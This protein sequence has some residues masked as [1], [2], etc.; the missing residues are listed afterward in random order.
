MFYQWK[1]D[2]RIIPGACSNELS[3]SDVISSD[4]G[5][6]TV[7][8][9]NRYGSTESNA[10]TLNVNRSPQIAIKEP[11]R[12]EIS[13]G[14]SITLGVRAMDTRPLLYQWI[15]DG[16]NISGAT[17]STYTVRNVTKND[18]G[19]YRVLV[20]NGNCQAESNIGTLKVVQVICKP[21][22]SNRS[23]S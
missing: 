4:A 9:S 12:R 2:G 18:T 10:A 22:C 20:S 16:L 3:I 5:N 7:V 21:R 11:T 13:A 23:I 6:Y 19:N 8:V 17:S 15:K 14:E 1:K